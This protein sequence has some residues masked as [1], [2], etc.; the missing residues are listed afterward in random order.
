MFDPLDEDDPDPWPDEP[1]EPDPEPELG[2]PADEL[3]SVPE[4]SVPDTDEVDAET[5]TTFWASVL[6]ANGAVLLVSLGPML[7][8]FRGQTLLGGGL[9]VAGCLLFARLYVYYRSFR[10]DDEASDGDGSDADD[11]GPESDGATLAEADASAASP[12]ENA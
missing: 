10:S 6:L 9:F 1:T 7:A 11:P 12:E 2:S 5:R 4:P 8:F 3:A